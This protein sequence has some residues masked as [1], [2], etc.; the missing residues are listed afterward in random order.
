MTEE[1]MNKCEITR[2]SSAATKSC[3][4]DSVVIDADLI[5]AK[6]HD[7]RQSDRKRDIHIF[8]SGDQDPLQR[9]LNAVQPGSYITPHRHYSPPKSESIVV[10]RGVLACVSFDDDGS[11]LEAD[12]ALLDPR[13]GIYGVD[14]RPSVWHTIFA[15]ERDTVVFEAKSGPYHPSA[16]EGF[17][18]WAPPEV[19]SEALKYLMELED[20]FRS[21]WKL[22]PRSWGGMA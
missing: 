3:H 17:A 16:D 7:A 14:I 2:I 12:F 21:F 20:Q 18:P 1:Q 10:L 19:S 6:A 13:R 8:H 5:S 9:M 4:K 11:P 15:L 22:T